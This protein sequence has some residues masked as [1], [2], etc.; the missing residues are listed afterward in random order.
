MRLGNESMRGARP[1][2]TTSNGRVKVR[3]GNMTVVRGLSD[4]EIKKAEKEA[5]K[6]IAE[7][8]RKQDATARKKAAQLAKKR[9]RSRRAAGG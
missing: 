4:K 5:A 1:Y 8:K 6:K 2:T 7:A 9:E 3:G